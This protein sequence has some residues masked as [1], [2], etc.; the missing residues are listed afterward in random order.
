MSRRGCPEYNVFASGWC[1][2]SAFK[3]ATRYLVAN[4]F[5]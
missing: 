2:Y 5:G 4:V 3:L 1:W